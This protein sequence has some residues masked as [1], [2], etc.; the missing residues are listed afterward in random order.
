MREQYTDDAA[1]IVM[2]LLV[3]DRDPN[4]N[5]IRKHASNLTALQDGRLQMG[6]IVLTPDE[7]ATGRLIG[8]TV[9]HALQPT[10]E[11]IPAGCKLPLLVFSP[12]YQIMAAQQGGALTAAHGSRA[13]I[14]LPKTASEIANYLHGISAGAFRGN[15]I[16]KNLCGE[17]IEATA[18]FLA[19]IRVSHSAVF[20]ALLSEDIDLAVSLEPSLDDPASA[21]GAEW[22]KAYFAKA[23]RP[24]AENFRALRITRCG[25]SCLKELKKSDAFTVAN[26]QIAKNQMEKGTVS[27]SSE[28]IIERAGDT[29]YAFNKVVCLD[30]DRHNK[31]R[32][33]K[34][35]GK[36]SAEKYS[37]KRK[38]SDFRTL[39]HYERLIQKDYVYGQRVIEHVIR[40]ATANLPSAPTCA[41][42]SPEVS[43]VERERIA[44]KGGQRY[45]SLANHY[46][47]RRENCAIQVGIA[48]AGLPGFKKSLHAIAQFANALLR[49]IW[50]SSGSNASMRNDHVEREARLVAAGMPAKG[51]FMHSISFEAS[52]WDQV[53]T[54]LQQWI[55]LARSPG[56]PHPAATKFTELR[57]YFYLLTHDVGKLL[58]LGMA[59]RVFCHLVPCV[60][61]FSTDPIWLR[62][63]ERVAVINN[64]T[65]DDQGPR[66]V[67]TGLFGPVPK[68]IADVIGLLSHPPDLAHLAAGTTFAG[69]LP[70]RPSPGP[71]RRWH[72]GSRERYFSRQGTGYRD[73]LPSAREG[74]RRN[75]RW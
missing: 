72:E 9:G 73:P 23:G 7:R 74:S 36:L 42:P 33:D 12:V 15:K 5:D 40:E 75:S 17:T 1:N 54:D 25:V 46:G 3:K 27:A 51:Q 11:Q 39:L 26:L 70:R 10:D 57:H 34:A 6:N 20:L 53:E 48:I 69:G 16:F 35:A 64:I 59:A 61:L 32:A 4:R 62:L 29:I 8:L 21:L 19:G 55:V 66:A 58:D 50:P 30:L 52:S 67:R 44:G 24:I 45:E 71:F 31:F 14:K 2:R 38:G 56:G 49:A 37:F 43:D 60:N 63:K 68:T 41:K 13:L 28:E 22:G 18:N 47:R 65:L